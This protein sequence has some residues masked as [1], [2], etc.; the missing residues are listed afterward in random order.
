MQKSRIHHGLY[1]IVD[2][3]K[4]EIFYPSDIPNNNLSRFGSWAGQLG[5]G[6]AVSIR[7]Y[8]GI[9][10]NIS[11]TMMSSGDTASLSTRGRL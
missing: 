9:S 10:A 8:I 6:R 1:D 5:D 4:N 3:S 2:T 11:E 7:K